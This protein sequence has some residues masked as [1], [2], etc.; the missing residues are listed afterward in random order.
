MNSDSVYLWTLPMFHCNGWC[1]PWAVTAVSGTHVCLRKVDPNKIW[2]LIETEKVSVFC[3]APTVQI[4]L[5]THA[6]ARPLE[7][8]VTVFV[9]GAPPS[10]TLLNQMKSCHFRP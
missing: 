5:V 6:K 2:D 3:G 1:F 10:P 9:A 7:R 4:M 8:E